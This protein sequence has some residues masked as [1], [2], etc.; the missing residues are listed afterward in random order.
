MRNQMQAKQK[1]SSIDFDNVEKGGFSAQSVIG[2]RVTRQMK[3]FI[4]IRSPDKIND[5]FK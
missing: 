1:Q 3:Y 5:E 2:V 4:F